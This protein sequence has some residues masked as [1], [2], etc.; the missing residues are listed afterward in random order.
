MDLWL[1]QVEL[2]FHSAILDR[3]ISVPVGYLTDLATIPWWARWFMS[4]ASMHIRAAAVIHDYC[5]TH[6]CSSMS[7]SQ[8]DLVLR[9]AMGCVTVP[10]SMWKR[11]VVWVAVRLG[12]RGA[13]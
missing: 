9:E 4:P 6:L 2:K 13:W 8:A 1:N 3:V 12:G 5:Y 7:R 10:A 11:N